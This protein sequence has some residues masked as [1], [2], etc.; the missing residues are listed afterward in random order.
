[1][2]LSSLGNFDLN[3]QGVSSSAFFDAETSAREFTVAVSDYGV[4]VLGDHL[5]TGAA[6]RLVGV[7]LLLTAQSHHD[8]D[9]AS[10]AL[11]SVDG[12]LLPHG[13]ISDLP[14]VDFY[15]DG[16]VLVVTADN[17]DIG[18]AV[19]LEELADLLW[20]VTH[21]GRTAFT[22]AARQLNM[23]GVEPHVEV[24][25]DSC[26]R[27]TRPDSAPWPAYDCW[28]LR[29]TACRSSRRSGGI[30]A[31][32]R[33]PYTPGFAAPSWRRGDWSRL[34]AVAHRGRGV[35][36]HREGDRT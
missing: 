4:T 22:P 29:G 32:A 15:S 21:H 2:G 16:W 9:H 11:R 19:K 17:A 27:A 30:R 36:P 13:C 31:T 10:E 12:M 14:S 18:D 24:V 28:T 35:V 7:R 34:S 26:S 3:L 20:V 6:R 5:A 23:M 1:M 25:V 8:V 33:G